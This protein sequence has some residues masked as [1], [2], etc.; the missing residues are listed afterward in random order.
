MSMSALFESEQGSISQTHIVERQL[1]LRQIPLLYNTTAGPS[2]HAGP[3]HQAQVLENLFGNL[4]TNWLYSATI[5]IALN[6]SQPA[7]SLD[8][9]SFVP[10]DV[11]GISNSL[12]AQGR[13]E[14][15]E[16]GLLPVATNITVST[17]GIR[18]RIE[19]TPYDNLNNISAW[20]TEWD[21]TNSTVWNVSSN[22]KDM[23]TGYELRA[24]RTTFRNNFLDTSFLGN[25]S[26]PRCCV[27]ETASDPAQAPAAIGY[28]SPFD[29]A[30]F[31]FPSSIWPRNFTTK[32]IY[33]DLRDGYNMST[34]YRGSGSSSTS[35]E[36]MLYMDKPSIQALRCKPIIES[37]AAKVT[38]GQSNGK[39]QSF[40][41]LEE[42]IIIDTPWTDGLLRHEL[43]VNRTSS[44]DE[45]SYNVTAR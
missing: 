33:G 25:P 36:H 44:D 11:N 30:E 13:N 27:N 41:I 34:K 21:L 26:R 24:G 45:V 29:A 10:I 8:G 7:W 20:L 42:P 15:T 6:G 40:D 16:K 2:V 35:P 43:A 12:A 23:D 28:W 38:V 1:E 37:A 39:V 17:P 9:W 5:Q 32:W 3:S 14:L 19:C 4:S 18:G 22:P 31:P